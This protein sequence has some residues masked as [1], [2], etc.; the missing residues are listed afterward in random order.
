MHSTQLS[1]VNRYR[2]KHGL[3]KLKA[4]YQMNKIANGHSRYMARNNTCN[5]AGFHERAAKLAKLTG[6]NYV[7]E[8]CF[9]LPAQRYDTR[10]AQK[11]VKGWMESPSHRQNLLNPK[12][13]KI[14]MGIVTKRGYVYATQIFSA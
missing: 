10:V 4:Y 11:L 1:F 12:F 3:N 9:Q 14:G 7:A 5:H 2:R 13:K 6:S 8:N